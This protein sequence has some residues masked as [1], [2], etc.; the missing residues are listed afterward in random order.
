MTPK[1]AFTG[2]APTVM[3]AK[4]LREKQSETSAELVQD[5]FLYYSQFDFT[6]AISLDPVNDVTVDKMTIFGVI[7]L[8]TTVT[9]IEKKDDGKLFEVRQKGESENGE[10]DRRKCQHYF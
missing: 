5:F 7:D 6:N 1:T 9:K 2:I 3:T 10:D 4:V 8:V